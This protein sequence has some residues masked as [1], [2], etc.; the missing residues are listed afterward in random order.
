MDPTLVL[1]T[2]AFT[3]EQLQGADTPQIA[4]AGRSNVGKSSLINALAGRKQ[5]AKT[6]STPGKTRS[7]NYYRV[8]PDNFFLV[9]LPGY[10][11]AKCSK[12]EQERWA[13]LIEQYL[14]SAKALRGLV[15]LLDCRLPPQ[16]S[17]LA[18]LSFASA[19]GVRC[20]P[21]LTK[22]DKCTRNERQKRQKDWTALLPAPPIITSSLDRTGLDAL[23]QA[24]RDM[25]TD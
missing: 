22:A 8:Q 6:S 20:I 18:M 10:G 24:M 21:I 2:T 16:K 13:A 15:V 5:L 7:V 3:L 9:D 1:E 4:L 25:A 11:Y 12:T 19:N 17:D 14:V 23:W